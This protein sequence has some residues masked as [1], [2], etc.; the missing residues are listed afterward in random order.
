MNRL[1]IAASA[2]SLLLGLWTPLTAQEIQTGADVFTDTVATPTTAAAAV[3][4]ALPL[5][6]RL[7]PTD[8]GRIDLPLPVLEA[9]I[10]AMLKAQVQPSQT[11][12]PLN[13]RLR[14]ILD[15]TPE[16]LADLGVLERDYQQELE[17]IGAQ[18]GDNS[19]TAPV[20]RQRF[21]AAAAMHRQR[22]EALLS[23]E[24]LALIERAR[25]HTVRLPRA[26]I[27]PSA[28]WNLTRHLQPAP[29]Q[30]AAW[31][32]ILRQQ[33]RLLWE[34]RQ[35]GGEPSRQA[36][37][38]LLSEHRMALQ[39]LLSPEQSRELAAARQARQTPPAE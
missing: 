16:Q 5:P 37:R 20:A 38:Q 30:I 13:Q 36:L 25:Y 31:Y 29:N 26:E 2:A 14:R 8:L 33:R 39:D 19:M 4:A 24:Q 32:R 1:R 15:L 18:I 34:M 28:A 11:V 7:D 27:H 9:S 22:R 17:W 12:P 21:R 6:V 3:A 10:I 23:P 35:A